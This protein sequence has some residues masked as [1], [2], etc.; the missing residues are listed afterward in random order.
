MAIRTSPQADSRQPLAMPASGGAI[1][2]ATGVLTVATAPRVNDIWRMVRLP[3][4]IQVV[5]GFVYAS[6]LDSG[7]PKTLDL[8]FGWE[9]SGD[10]AA[11]PAGFGKA[12]V[13]INDPVNAEA[14]GYQFM[15]GGV[16]KAG[17][18]VF[19]YEMVLS[20]KVIAQ[21]AAFSPGTLS[22][23]ALYRGV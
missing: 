11:D 23:V 16:L 2:A 21:P 6:V 9:A 3:R 8:D 7:T 10:E 18:K 19:P 15:F 12:S 17:P 14:A 5:G 20:F 1:C 22:V 13:N 4:N